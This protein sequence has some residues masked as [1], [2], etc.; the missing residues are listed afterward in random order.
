MA[1][2]TGRTLAAVAALAASAALLLGAGAAWA[3]VQPAPPAC[4]P[5]LGVG[6]VETGPAG[7]DPRSQVYVLDHVRP[8][9]TFTRRFQV[10]N[11]TAAP[12]TV[13]LHP[14]AVT[15]EHGGFTVLAGTAGNELTR[16]ISISPAQ[17]SLAPGER[18]LA[19]ATFTVPA[20]AVA[21][22]RYGALLAQLP[23]QV[24]RV[25][26]AVVDQVGVR[27][28]LSV[29]PGGDPPSDFVVDSLQAVRRP[30]GTPAVLA[31]VRNTGLR[32]VDLQGTLRLAGGPGGLAAGPFPAQLGTTL[33][34][35]D[36]APVAVTLD[37]AITG[38]PW[39]A[40]I[41]LRSGDLERKAQAV[42]SFPVAAGGQELPV[43]AAAVSIL[44]DRGILVPLAA[45]LV[46]LLLVVLAVV[47]GHTRRHRRRSAG[48]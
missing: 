45:G 14:G 27:V 32:A 18:T 48:A 7:A 16:W 23:P 25:G 15:I 1:D 26:V 10:C 9:T 37:R 47:T 44:V 42:L 28:Y 5:G 43:R 12:M 34:P 19:T 8:G 2:R 6:L 31:R 38:G 39:Q 24:G 46:A 29:G 3:G 17:V 20:N 36:S 22:E 40:E 11:G 4:Q 21:G 13:L 33:K 41:D 35:G 30:D